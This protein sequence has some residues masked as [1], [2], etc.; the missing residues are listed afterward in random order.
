MSSLSDVSEI[1]RSFLIDVTF[2][3]NHKLA[4]VDM[5]GPV[6]ANPVVERLL[7]SLLHVKAVA[8]LDHA[9]QLWID[10]K[11][12]VVPRP[13]RS[14]LNGRINFLADY[15]HIAD[16]APLHAIRGTRNLLA[17]DPSGEV[18]W[19][20]LDRDVIIVHAA[21]FELMIVKPMPT[22]EVS[23]ERSGAGEGEILNAA[24]TFHYAV[25]IKD[26]DKKIA[27]ITWSTHLMKEGA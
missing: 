7:P 10:D 11:G 21:L 24:C 2:A 13:Y 18:D 19:A 15:N 16:R 23:A 5:P 26:G 6:P 14:D 3:K 22:W 12:L 4:Y 1:W 9:L 17:H 8:I 25:R 20:E 27:E